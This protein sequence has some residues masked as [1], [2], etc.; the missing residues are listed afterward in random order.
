MVQKKT[1]D[2]QTEPKRA[3]GRPRAYDAE[4]ALKRARDTF[5]QSGY[6]ATTLDDLSA[7]TGMNRPSLYGAFG[8]KRALYLAT[9]QRYIEVSRA[10]MD[11]A[12]AG[13]LPLGEALLH[14]YDLAL[15]MYYRAGSAATGCF[16]TGTAVAEAIN[17]E[18]VRS[19]LAD[20]LRVFDRSFEARFM[21]AQHGGE[22]D[23]NAD[24]AMLAK[25][26]SAILH[27]LAIRSRAGDKRAVLRATAEA[28]V[29]MICG[30][31]PGAGSRG[32]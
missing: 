1:E 28:G 16:L 8:D 2:E 11:Q 14:V 22:L 17:D 29:A 3:R 4:D 31:G 13:D 19:I 21:R 18:D 5:W 24:P 10:G 23:P 27:S 15:G 7:A 12:L 32:K 30:A 25:V 6:S 9:L 20:G 26:A